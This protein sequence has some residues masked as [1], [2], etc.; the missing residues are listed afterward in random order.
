MD[1][2]MEILLQDSVNNIIS[3]GSSDGESWR[4]DKHARFEREENFTDDDG[5]CDDLAGKK[6]TVVLSG[7]EVQV[8][9]NG[10]GGDS[11]GD[12]DRNHKVVDGEHQHGT[13]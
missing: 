1:P 3:S 9:D 7:S 6:D 5:N 2:T 13:W 10:N 4:D 11:D 12:D 8:D